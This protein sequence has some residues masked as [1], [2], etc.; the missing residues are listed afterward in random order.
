VTDFLLVLR[1]LLT[2]PASWLLFSK[3]KSL[4]RLH[5]LRPTPRTSGVH[6]LAH[7]DSVSS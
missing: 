4:E 6:E 2:P 3:I 7:T 5:Q 1:R